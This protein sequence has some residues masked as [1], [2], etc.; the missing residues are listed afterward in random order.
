MAVVTF[1]SDYGHDDDFV[2]VCHGV[3]ARIAPDV[4]VI[5]VTHGIARHD[6]RGGALVLRRALQFMPAGVHLAVVDP[7]VGGPRRAVA[8]RCAGAGG[9]RVLVGPDNGL[10]SL[11]AARFGGVAEAVDI[12]RSRLRLEPVSASFH[13]RDV[14]APVAARLACADVTL[15]EAGEPLDPAGLVGLELPRARAT[16]GGLVAHALHADVYGNVVL[17]ASREDLAACGLRAGTAV[18]VNGVRGRYATTFAD[19]AAGE[20]LL[21]E[22]GYRSP[23]L[24]VNRG[25]ALARLGLR[26]DGEVLI[27][28]GAREPRTKRKLR[29]PAASRPASART[30]M[31]APLGRP[32]LHHRVTA[33][34]NDVA[35]AL[36]VA[37]APHGSLVTAGE[38]RA[39]RGRQGRTW[40]APAGRALLLSLVLRDW[41]VLLP[42]AAA[43]AVAEIAG[44]DAAIKWPNDVLIEGRKVAGILCEGRSQEGW[45]VL[46]VGVNVALREADLPPELAGRATSLGLEPAAIAAT[47]DGLLRALQRRLAQPATELLA[48]YRAR[49]ALLGRRVRWAHGEGVARGIDEAGRL[50]VR[51][52]DGSTATLDAGEVHLLA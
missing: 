29:R 49:D 27:A 1:L 6:V 39:G 17:D 7:G 21:Y 16:D 19:V 32:H 20:L 15:A 41:P 31:S 38:Q 12:G 46:G 30:A 5:D 52:A 25:S 22:D 13:G 47:R 44:P 42:I 4:R 51:Q 8:L 33:S 48:D 35:R 23:S 50:L 37:G 36:A 45:V 9:E 11:A 10:L 43:V 14:F 40:S 26:I 28:R 34:T 24:A 18:T 2:G 3:I